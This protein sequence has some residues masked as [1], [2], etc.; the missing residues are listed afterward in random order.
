MA[1]IHLQTIDFGS[2]MSELNTP[3]RI[4]LNGPSDWDQWISTIKKYALSQ[5]V[6]DQI[7]PSSLSRKE[8]IE[9]PDEPT[10]KTVKPSANGIKDLSMDELK[11]YEFLY[12]QYRT[13]LQSFKDQQKS[14]ASIQQYIIK[15]VGNYYSTISDEHNVA[16]E[17]SLLKSRVEP[18]EWIQQK[19]ILSKFQTILRSP[20]HIN[21]SQWITNWQKVCTEAKRV[22]LPE[23]EGLRPTQSFLEAVYTI[24]SSF[25]DY[26]TN[27]LEDEARINSLGWKERFPDGIEISEIFERTQSTKIAAD[28]ERPSYFA[29]FKGQQSLEVSP[30]S[31]SPRKSKPLCPCGWKHYYS[32]CF[33]LN[34]QSRPHSFKPSAEKQRKVDE[35][36]LNPSNKEKVEKALIK[37][38]KFRNKAHEKSRAGLSANQEEANG[39]IQAAAAVMMKSSFSEPIMTSFEYPLKRSFILD[40][41]SDGHIC[42]DFGRFSNF[43]PQEST[44]IAGVENQKF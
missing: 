31:D 42:N 21:I 9:L 30:Q 12:N 36:L 13:H 25:S 1:D 5:G 40:S 8:L 39:R 20:D 22:S 35:F 23:A 29:V 14:L 43:T 15:T 2:T 6:W 38:E 33:Y 44:V 18:S 4:Q 41:G 3:Q 7:D 24:N 11:I 17:L 19:E 28:M 32:E 26:W 34:K 16:E 27:K 10:Y 37:A